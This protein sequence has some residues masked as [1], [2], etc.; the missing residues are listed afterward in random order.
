[1]VSYH[2]QTQDQ[3]TYRTFIE[4]LHFK[5]HRLKSF[6]FVYHIMTYCQTSLH[7]GQAL[8]LPQSVTNTM[9]IKPSPKT[10]ILLRN[11]MIHQ[12]RLLQ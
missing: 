3:F 2:L 11:Y 9:V 8:Y 5:A 7:K 12:C 4:V 10:F 1:M 6:S